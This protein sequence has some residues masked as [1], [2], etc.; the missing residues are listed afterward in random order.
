MAQPESQQPLQRGSIAARK[1]WKFGCF[2]GNL[3]Q[4]LRYFVTKFPPNF[5]LFCG[6]NFH[7]TYSVLVQKFHK[8]WC[9]FIGT[10]PQKFAFFKK[11]PQISVKKNSQKKNFLE[12]IHKDLICWK[13]SRIILTFLVNFHNDFAVLGELQPK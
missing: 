10:F 6:R 12:N 4:N 2:C 7:K 5:I 8:N 1:L 9:H 3:N 13:I 11:I